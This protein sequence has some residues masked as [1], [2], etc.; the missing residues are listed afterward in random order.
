MKIAFHQI[1]SGSGRD[2][3]ET[4]KA[5]ADAG[6]MHFEVNLGETAQYVEQHGNA[7][8]AG[9]VREHG[10]DCIAATGLSIEAFSGADGRS[11]NE[12]ALR[13]AGETMDAL[14]CRPIV[15]GGGGPPADGSPAF[16]PRANDSSERELFRRDATYR[17][18]L[19]QFAEEV[20]RLAAIAD[21]YG[22]ALALE[23][24]WCGMA[25]S[26][27]TM[28]ELVALVDRDNVGAVWDPAHFY[29]TPSRLDDLDL[30]D[31]KIIHA[32]LNDFRNCVMEV[33]DINGDRV[34]PGEGVLP[35]V[36]WTKK[37]E[38]VGYTGWHSAELFSDDLWAKSLPEIMQDVKAGCDSVWPGA[39]F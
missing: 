7:G 30:L 16:P 24:N 4:F 6:W 21:E 26:I 29:S 17:T 38:S 2:L 37:I 1:T 14:G 15:C 28:A 20:R 22:V 5:Y 32:H 36:E 9:L 25:R 23:V 3:R 11:A 33:M 39:E 18:Q 27:R 8:L 13:A 10:L 31:G 19:E 12:S 35:L 34:I